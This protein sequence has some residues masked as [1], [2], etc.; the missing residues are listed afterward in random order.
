MRPDVPGNF[1]EPG[2]LPVH[3]CRD[4]DVGTGLD[5]VRHGVGAVVHAE[6]SCRSKVAAV[7]EAAEGELAAGAGRSGVA[8]DAAGV[9]LPEERVPCVVV[10][11]K[12]RGG[13]TVPARV[14]LRDRLLQS[15][16]LTT[17]D[18]PSHN[19]A[20]QQQVGQGSYG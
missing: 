16:I 14:R 7:T 2:V 4:R 3:A 6:S 9:D 20:L 17:S 5:H 13:K 18:G 15:T 12:D 10:S 11:G 8:V 19:P 1:L